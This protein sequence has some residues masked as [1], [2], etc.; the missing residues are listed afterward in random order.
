MDVPRIFPHRRNADGSYDSICP[1][2]FLTASHAA[3]EA[4]L[5]AQDGEHVCRMTLLS[6][7]G[8]GGAGPDLADVRQLG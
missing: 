3:S 2:C 8:R 1:T 7:R 5:A 4:E 6:Q